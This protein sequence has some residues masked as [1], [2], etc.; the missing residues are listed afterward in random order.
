MDK[1]SLISS[2]PIF[3]PSVDNIFTRSYFETKGEPSGRKL[4]R[5]DKA[6]VI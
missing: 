4:P 1:H 5:M 3:S 6:L 2:S